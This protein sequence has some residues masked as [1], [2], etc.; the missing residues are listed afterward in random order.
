VVLLAVCGVV[1]GGLQTPW[2]VIIWLLVFH[3]ITNQRR[4]TSTPMSA[5][6]L[7]L[8]ET[9]PLQWLGRISYSVYLVHIPVLYAVFHVLSHI[10][11]GLRNWQFLAVA[12]PATLIITTGI[13]ALTYRWI[14]QPGIRLGKQLS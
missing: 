14:E 13:S 1:F 9:A 10:A 11:P 3:L 5:V 2:P 12:L 6:S 4:G 7:S 8:M